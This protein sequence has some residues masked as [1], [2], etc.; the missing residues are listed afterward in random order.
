[1]LTPRRAVTPRSTRARAAATEQVNPAVTP[2]K[3]APVLSLTKAESPVSRRTD[4][5]E[6]KHNSSHQQEGR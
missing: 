3:K 2:A 6:V 4:K 5:D 1:M